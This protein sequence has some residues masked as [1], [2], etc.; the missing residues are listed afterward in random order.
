MTSEVRRLHEQLS[1]IGLRA[2]TV[3]WLEW[4]HEYCPAAVI[5]EAEVEEAWERAK[6]PSS[7]Q[8]VSAA[9]RPAASS[10]ED[11]SEAGCGS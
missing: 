10:A 1:D 8:V 11:G 2:G 6:T 3:R 9:L 5:R 4:G 7:T